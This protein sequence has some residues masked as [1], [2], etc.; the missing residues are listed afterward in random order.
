MAKF[1]RHQQ[2]IISNYYKNRE[3]ISLQRLQE[4]VTE[5]YLSEGKKRQRHWESIAKN[6]AHAGVKQAQIDHLVAQRRDQGSGR[7]HLADRH[8][9]DPDR[10]H[11]AWVD[12]GGQPA[13]A[14]AQRADVLA[15]TDRVVQQPRRTEDGIADDGQAVQEIH[16]WEVLGSIRRLV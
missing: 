2:G 11:P 7:Q 9:M 16:R 4:L 12:R 15:V 14:L 8:G 6:L 10:R 13:P 1:S 5:L 3:A